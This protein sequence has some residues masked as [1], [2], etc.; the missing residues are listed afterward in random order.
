MSASTLFTPIQV[1]RYELANRIVMSPLTR[2]RCTPDTHT[3]TPMMKEYYAQR[4]SA[5]LIIAEG[6]MI[7]PD[8]CTF[9]AQPGVYT[10][11][12]LVAWKEITD[13]VHAKGGK[14]FV[15]LHHPG[16]ATHPVMNNGATPRA[17]S[18][19][20][21]DGEI[22]THEGKL[23]YPTP[24]ELTQNEIADIVQQ[25]ATAA[26][27]SVEKAGFDGVEIHSGNGFLIDQFL[28]D[29]ANKRTDAY[30]G[31][32]ENRSRFLREV[33]AA[34]SDAIGSDRIGLHISPLSTYNNISDSD[35]AGLLKYLATLL[36]DFNVAFVLLLRRDL[37]GNVEGDCA[38]E[39]RKLYHGTIIGNIGFTKTEATEAIGQ[40][41]FDAVAF[42]L[43]FVANPDLVAR[44][45]KDASLNA[46]DPSTLYT[47]DTKGYTDY[48]TLSD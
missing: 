45:E 43:P 25:Y 34:V 22:H 24:K 42:G 46:P 9:Y 7:A 2:C 19:I 35:N 10:N 38:A 4:A 30:G 12:Q 13:A 31:S 23:P 15:Q 8:T 14:I 18:A 1:G 27:N 17:P 32:F 3:P 37:A 44:F 33:V 16:R 20:S 29:G 47:Q 21:I 5:G 26:F 40:K 36:N 39:F 6:T 11:E 41:Q 28:R 48:P